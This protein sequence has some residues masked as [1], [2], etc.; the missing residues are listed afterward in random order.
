[1]SGLNYETQADFQRDYPQAPEWAVAFFNEM[2]SLKTSVERI[3]AKVDLNRT[4][5]KEAK[6]LGVENKSKIE[7][8]ETKLETLEKRMVDQEDY[9]RR[10][11]LKIYGIPESDKETP[12]NLLDTISTMFKN[13]MKLNY[14]IKIEKAHR[15]GRQFNKSNPRPIIVR[16]NC[17]QDRMAVWNLRYS[18]KN[19]HEENPNKRPNV[20][21]REDYSPTTE[22]NRRALQPYLRGAKIAGKKYASLRG[23]VLRIDGV[24]YTADKVNSIPEIY[25]PSSYASIEK[26]NI[27]LFH[28]KESPLSNFHPSKFTIAG[29]E[30]SDNE[31]FY[32]SKKAEFF[33][34]HTTAAKI[35]M[36]NSPLDSYKLAFK[37]QGFNREKWG[38]VEQDV[39]LEGALAKFSQNE[40]C[41]N[42]LL[43]T[44]EKT[45]AEG[46]TDKTWAT[47]L[48][49]AHPDAFD[50][51]R[52]TGKNLLDEVL[53]EVRKRLL[54]L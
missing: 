39:M 19:Y 53:T 54:G 29:Q 12:E 7:D 41:R 33:S 9:S 17:F 32:Q 30:Y 5:A 28:G 4:L 52:W 10:S 42:S 50:K 35:K 6:Q 11:N 13:V 25:H 2:R 40:N 23:S 22:A 3:E 46:S 15:I 16:F 51:A 34:D 24:Q 8:L 37:I 38:T 47:G 48:P 20:I 43:A 31:M 14:D 44:N 45:L 27:I 26:N 1:M 18:L 21:I 49:L 36:A